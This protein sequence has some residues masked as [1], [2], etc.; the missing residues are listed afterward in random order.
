MRVRVCYADCELSL[1]GKTFLATLIPLPM[2]EFDVILGMDFLSTYRAKIDCLRKEVTFCLP[3]GEKIKFFGEKRAVQC[4]V[5]SSLKARALLSK[6]YEGFIAYVVDS[7]QPNL[8]IDS[9]PMVRDFPDVF[10]EELPGVVP[11]RDI[12]FTIELVSGASPI[13]IAPYR[14]APTELL[15]LKVQLFYYLDK[16]FIRPSMSPWGAPVLFVKK[17]DGS[18]RMCIDYRQLNKLTIRNKYPLPRIN[19]LFDQL[20]GSVVFLKIDLRSGYY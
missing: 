4:R 5:I 8:S 17:K 6:G 15:E 9:I 16:G 2:I 10:P 14:M 7:S 3:T 1:D 12:E 20:Q 13:S 11:D 18:L 19:D